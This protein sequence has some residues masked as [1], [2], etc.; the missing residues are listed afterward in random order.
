MDGGQE[1][2]R[3]ALQPYQVLASR[4]RAAASDPTRVRGKECSL[5][6]IIAMASSCLHMLTC[7]TASAQHQPRVAAQACALQRIA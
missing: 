4:R 2:G 1:G 6:C 5:Q 3:A 7:P